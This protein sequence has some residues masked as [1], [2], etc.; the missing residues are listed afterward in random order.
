MKFSKCREYSHFPLKQH[1]TFLLVIKFL[2]SIAT[3]IYVAA[4]AV[5]KKTLS[6]IDKLVAVAVVACKL[7]HTSQKMPN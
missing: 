1:I 4:M 3:E 2:F 5:A 7:D 6:H